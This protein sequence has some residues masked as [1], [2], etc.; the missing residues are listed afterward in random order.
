M[1]FVGEGGR[2][3]WRTVFGWSPDRGTVPEP[4]VWVTGPAGT[5]RTARRDETGDEARPGTRILLTAQPCDPHVEYTAQLDAAFAALAG[6]AVD[7][8][9]CAAALRPACA[10]TTVLHAVQNSPNTG[11]PWEFT[12]PGLL[13]PGLLNPGPI[14]EEQ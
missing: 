8:G 14:K 9:P 5:G 1:E 12:T 6:Y 13:N 2:L 10:T 11:T 7:P 4:R 3:V